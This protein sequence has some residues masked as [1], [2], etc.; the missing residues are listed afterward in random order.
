MRAYSNTQLQF[1]QDR[2]SALLDRP[3][4]HLVN[5]PSAE[6]L[7]PVRVELKDSNGEVAKANSPDT[8]A[9]HRPES[10][11]LGLGIPK[12]RQPRIQHQLLILIGALHCIFFADCGGTWRHCTAWPRLGGG[13]LRIRFA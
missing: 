8:T 3:T 13:S 9:A 2:P 7:R 4:L 10:S 12:R 1:W 11:T 5:D 6:V